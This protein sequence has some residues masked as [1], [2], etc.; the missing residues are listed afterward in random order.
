VITSWTCSAAEIGSLGCTAA[1]T[2]CDRAT[3]RML[4]ARFPFAVCYR[5]ERGELCAAVLDWPCDLPGSERHHWPQMA[6]YFTD[7]RKSPTHGEHRGEPLGGGETAARLLRSASQPIR[8]ALSAPRTCGG[9]RS[10]VCVGQNAE[11]RRYRDDPR[12]PNDYLSSSPSTSCR[13]HRSSS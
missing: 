1:S 4:S 10:P 9:G 12:A 2:R 5:I 7:G 6:R 13:S 11:L 3:H 8:I